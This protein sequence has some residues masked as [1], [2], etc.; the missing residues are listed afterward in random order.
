MDGFSA[1]VRFRVGQ[2]LLATTRWAVR[3][4]PGFR[5]GLLRSYRR[6]RG[7]SQRLPRWLLASLVDATA[8]GK[9]AD[10]KHGDR[11]R[12]RLGN[13]YVGDERFVLAVGIATISDNRTA[14]S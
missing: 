9:R 13:R 2:L 8:G 1:E 12:C 6:E 7:Q 5:A 10:A 14:V 3:G 4:E 11:N